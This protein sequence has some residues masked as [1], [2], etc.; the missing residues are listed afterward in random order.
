MMIFAGGRSAHPD[1]AD[2]LRDCRRA[3]ASV[4]LFSG[5]VN[6]L[7]LA[8]P[9]YM[10]QV[11]DR[12]LNSRSVPTLVALSLLLV[13]A[14]AFQGALDLIRSR[15]VVR[16]AALLDQR[17]A[18]AVHGAVIR[19]A[20]ATPQT[21]E[22][23]Q[24]VRDLDQI[25][26]FLTGAGP[27]AIVDLPWV[28]AFLLICFLIHPWLGVAATAGGVLL[29]TMTLLTERASRAPARVAA[30]E[31]G[32]RLVMV[33]ANRRSGESIVAMGMAGALAQRWSA[34]NSRYITA[35]A[36]LSDVAGSFGSVSKVLRLLLQ[37]MMLGLGAY[38][39][40]RQELTAG[41][42]IA[43]SIMM[44]RALAPIE[45]AIA[46]WRAFVAARQSVGRL[47]E[48]LARVAPKRDTTTLPRPARSLEVEHVAVVAPGGTTP[49]VTGARFGLKSGEVLGIIGPSGAGK[50]SLVRTLVGV[51]RPAK[52][53]V[54]LDGA[55]LDHWD[56]EL[57]GQHVGFVSQT[58]ELFDGTITENIARMSVAPD[59]DAVLRAARAAGAHD[60]IL[61]LPA[62]YDTRIG[63]GG[64]M[65]SGGQRQRIALAR[66][67]HGDP[68]LVVLDEPNSN[69]DNEG[70][71]ALHQAILGLKSRGAIVVLIAHRPSVLAVCD[72]ILVLANG[73]Q[74][75]F[76]T[77][78]EILRKI[79]RRPA[80]PPA[81]AA[82][83]GNLKIVSDTT[84]GGQS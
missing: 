16:S 39:V 71:A 74:Q 22:G 35:N 69:L 67:L 70:D 43:A 8:G 2:A 54:R 48:A 19:L 41:A 14:Y 52:G 53:S 65:L 10:L 7:M 21:G 27:I 25:R 79:V 31:A 59:P 78:D 72:R 12:V 11:Y 63:E 42:M 76:G 49:I 3:F 46:N 56:P 24:P 83:V 75:D 62:G 81:A 77:R 61:R 36:R 40:I 84:G 29:F 47:S 1:L 82:A 57:L 28:P 9:L 51:W 23:P 68:F 64:A 58:V 50:S 5:V 60:M 4:A 37:S 45:T 30:K 33:E 44:G 6:L 13:G 38:L 66:A 55:T 26:A 32:T 20:I 18:L 80:P 17:L 73:G 15:V 34:I